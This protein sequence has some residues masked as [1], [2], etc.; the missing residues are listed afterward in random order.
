MPEK[1]AFQDFVPEDRTQMLDFDRRYEPL[2]SVIGRM[3][4]WLVSNGSPD[5]VQIE[6]LLLPASGVT[7]GDDPTTRSQ[8]STGMNWFQVIRV[9][10]RS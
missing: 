10:H 3:N 6:T 8:L 7:P 2:E 5:V 1:I 9:W 4:E